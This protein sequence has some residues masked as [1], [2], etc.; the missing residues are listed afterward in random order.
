MYGPNRVLHFYPLEIIANMAGIVDCKTDNFLGR[1]RLL[2]VCIC[3]N[4]SVVYASTCIET[5]R[6]VRLL[7]T[8]LIVA[9]NLL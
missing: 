3:R 1:W 5:G 7:M 9:S 8:M 2:I 4:Y 6:R